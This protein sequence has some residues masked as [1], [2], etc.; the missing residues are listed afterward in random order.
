[1]HK[2]KYVYIQ[3]YVKLRHPQLADFEHNK[4]INYSFL[5]LVQKPKAKSRANT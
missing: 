1:M 4:L 2:Y 3:I 5:L